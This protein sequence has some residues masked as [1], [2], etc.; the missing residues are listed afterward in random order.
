M[1]V[2]G[3]DFVN[4]LI[5][6]TDRNEMKLRYYFCGQVFGFCQLIKNVALLKLNRY[7]IKI[8]AC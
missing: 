4:D 8:L 6:V 1:V 7:R 3:C 2:V 5:I